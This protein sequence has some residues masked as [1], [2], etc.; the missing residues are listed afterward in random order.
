MHHHRAIDPWPMA[1]Y[2][3]YMHCIA[4]TV[5]QICILAI[6][7]GYMHCIAH[8]VVYMYTPSAL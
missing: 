7:T 2:T 8:T 6:Y 5:V 3:G 4:H 1:I